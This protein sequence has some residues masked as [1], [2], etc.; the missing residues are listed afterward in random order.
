MGSNGRGRF[1]FFAMG[2]KKV[3]VRPGVL[4]EKN[5]DGPIPI[6][7]LFREPVPAPRPAGESRGG[8]EAALREAEEVSPLEDDLAREG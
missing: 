1:G 7:G 6:P 4:G 8:A 5:D 3:V 2:A